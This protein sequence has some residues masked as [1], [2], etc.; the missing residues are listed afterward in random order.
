[1]S[2][3]TSIRLGNEWHTAK[4]KTPSREAARAG[5]KQQAGA[6]RIGSKPPVA[7]SWAALR[8]SDAE[9]EPVGN[10]RIVGQHELMTW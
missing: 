10:S 8:P 4:A 6:V 9:L 5:K 2:P 1:V 3:N 7:R